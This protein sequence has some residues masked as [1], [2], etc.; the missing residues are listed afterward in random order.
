MP[1]LK[2]PTLF[3]PRFLSCRP[4]KLTREAWYLCEHGALRFAESRERVR[5]IFDIELVT[6]TLRAAA[7][8]RLM[9]EGRLRSP[10][11][12]RRWQLAKW[13]WRLRRLSAWLV[14][15]ADDV[16][17]AVES[18]GRTFAPIERRAVVI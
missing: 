14:G 8:L 6:T 17:I 18:P 3:I 7:N 9:G 5:I 13:Q 10:L 4:P 16:E 1:G 2:A 11:P 15:R 12:P